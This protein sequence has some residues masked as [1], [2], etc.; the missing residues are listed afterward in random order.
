ME[1]DYSNKVEEVASNREDKIRYSIMYNKYYLTGN[2][3]LSPM[4]LSINYKD[5][6]DISLMPSF[7]YIAE[8]LF[9]SFNDRIKIP[10]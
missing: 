5:K 9:K 8:Y 3:S 7:E 6:V 10:I 1:Q 4:L 2:N